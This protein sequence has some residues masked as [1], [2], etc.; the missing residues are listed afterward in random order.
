MYDKAGVELYRRL[1][2]A[3]KAGDLAALRDLCG[4]PP[5]FPNVWPPHDAISCSVLQYALY[6]SP[7]DFV[8]ELL[9]SGADPNYDDGDG[10]PS[11]MATLTSGR[12]PA[13]VRELLTLLLDA[14]ADANQHGHNDYTPLHWAAAAGD[15][16]IV[17]FL[18]ARGA[19]ASVKTR[20]DDYETPAEGA[21]RAGHNDL[22]EILRRAERR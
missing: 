17:E 6:H 16:D 10:F 19:D 20:I 9:Q 22:A 7:V 15:S 8:R 11:L 4:N 13:V 12:P 21:Q 18:L 5:D 14:G 1:D 2:G 3:F